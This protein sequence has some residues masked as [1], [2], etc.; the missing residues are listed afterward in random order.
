MSPGSRPSRASR[1]SASRSFSPQSIRTRV[2]PAS[3]TRLFLLLPLPSDAK[4]SNLLFQLLVEEREDAQRRLR[5]LGG[6]VLVEDVDLARV[7]VL[8]HLH[9]ILLGLHLGVL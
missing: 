2:E 5:A 9:A 1:R 3:A 7:L 8:L 4:R 6:A